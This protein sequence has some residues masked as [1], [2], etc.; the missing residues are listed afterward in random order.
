MHLRDPHI[1]TESLTHEMSDS[2]HIG[3]SRLAHSQ[4]EELCPLSRRSRDHDLSLDLIRQHRPRELGSR[5][6]ADHRIIDADTVP[7]LTEHEVLDHAVLM[8]PP[9]WL[10]E[11]VSSLTIV[12]V[13]SALLREAH[14]TMPHQL[15]RD[16]SIT[17]DPQRDARVDRLILRAQIFRID[18]VL[19]EIDV[20]I[21][22]HI[23]KRIAGESI[24]IL[25]A[26]HVSPCS[27]VA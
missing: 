14:H 10:D 13:S 17:C 8:L 19:T 1:I 26:E 22:A 5:A 16:A 11:G 20:G 27:H 12:D 7:H 9:P 18:D 4:D 24:S 3:M 25:Y 6:L 23:E 2:L 15:M 21:L